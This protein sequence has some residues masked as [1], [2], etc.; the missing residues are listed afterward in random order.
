MIDNR[1]LGLFPSHGAIRVKAMDNIDFVAA[2][3]QRIGQAMEIN[4]VS[5]E[6]VWRIENR[7][8]AESKRTRHFA[9]LHHAALHRK[10]KAVAERSFATR[11]D[12]PRI[13]L[14]SACVHGGS[15]Q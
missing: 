10:L 13:A 6:T 11:D 4:G 7:K 8:E 9:S 15:H 2:S 5:T 1:L 12:S 14:P 3:G